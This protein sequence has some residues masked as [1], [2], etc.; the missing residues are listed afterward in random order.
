MDPPPLTLLLGL[1]ML[2]TVA[3]VQAT[4]EYQQKLVPFEPANNIVK[5]NKTCSCCQKLGS[6]S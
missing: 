1:L 5:H 2:R 6:R 4:T 3:H